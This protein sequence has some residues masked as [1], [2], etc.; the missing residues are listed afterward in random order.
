ME[1][2]VSYFFM[3]GCLIIFAIGCYIAYCG[4]QDIRAENNQV[5]NKGQKQTKVASQGDYN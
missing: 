2:P 1:A 5:K 4:Y 3:I